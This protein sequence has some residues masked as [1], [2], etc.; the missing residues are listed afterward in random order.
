MLKILNEDRGLHTIFLRFSL[1]IVMEDLKYQVK[2]SIEMDQREVVREFE[3]K[4]FIGLGG[5]HSKI[6]RSGISEP[7][8]I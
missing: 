4:R 2:G 8:M 3:E 6:N 1:K 7:R 5:R